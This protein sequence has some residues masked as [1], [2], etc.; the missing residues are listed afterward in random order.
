MAKK[1]LTQEAKANVVG[2]A[3]SGAV[4]ARN[5]TG[6]AL[7]AAAAAA[8]E[9]VL[10][11]I[12]QALGSGSKSVASANAPRQLKGAITKSISGRRSTSAARKKRAKS[13]PAAKKPARAGRTPT[14]KSAVRK[15]SRK[16]AAGRSRKR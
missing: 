4:E 1:S 3:K 15:T 14:K 10:N 8:A 2:A 13:K 9:V 6:E 12:A 16:K 7:G 11:R 5:I